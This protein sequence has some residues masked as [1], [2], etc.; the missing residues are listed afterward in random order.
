MTDESDTQFHDRRA[1]EERTLAD[2]AVDG[3]HAIPRGQLSRLHA[4]EAKALGDD[5][6]RQDRPLEVS[7]VGGTVTVAGAADKV[8]LLTPEAAHLTADRLS[9]R[10]REAKQ[11]QRST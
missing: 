4:D 10:A 3:L 6:A 9:A 5:D 1:R 7:A 8:T 2:Q 11:Q